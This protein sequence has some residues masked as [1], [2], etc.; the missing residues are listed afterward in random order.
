MKILVID[1]NEIHRNA[2]KVQ[3]REHDLTV[4]STYDEG[5]SLLKESHP[6]EVVFTDL[7]LPASNYLQSSDKFVG[8][9]MM[10]GLFLALLAA[11]NGAKYVAVFT[12]KDHHHHPG[13]ACFREFNKE[14]GGFPVPFKVAGA[15]MVLC[16]RWV[17]EFEKEDLSKPAKWD[18]FD[19]TKIARA[20]DWGTLLDYITEVPKKYD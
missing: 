15:E 7:L 11:I 2:A 1:D 14:R 16:S 17:R 13:A 5:N 19:E 3:L 18:E 9:E 6:F 12:D 10:V 20:K 8:K 4:V